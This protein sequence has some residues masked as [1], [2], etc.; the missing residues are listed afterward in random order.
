MRALVQTYLAELRAIF[1]D[2]GVLLIM[3][4]AIFL[5]SFVYPVPYSDEILREVDVVVVDLDHTALSRQ[6]VRM[7]DASDLI[8]ISRRANNEEEARRMVTLGRASGVLAIP[9]DF[10]RRILRS[11]AAQVG[12]YADASYFLVYRQVLT[13]LVGASRT[14]S[15]GIEVRRLQAQGWFK[16]KALAARDPLQFIGFALFNPYLG[17]ATYIVP[18]VLVLLLQQTMLIGVGMLAGTRRESRL[19]GP[20]PADRR[21]GA[22]TILWG[23]AGAYLTVYFIHV[24]FI[25]GVVYRVWG[26]P[27]RNGQG[28]VALFLFPYLLSVA[29]LSQALAG[30]FKSREAAIPFLAWTSVVAVMVSGFSWPPEAMPIW[31]KALAGLLP[32][33]WG[34][35]G[36]LRVS[37]MG[38]DLSQVGVDWAW[39][40]GL[41]AGYAVLGWL[42]VRRELRRAAE[43]LTHS[44]L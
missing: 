9:A 8:R 11:E 15:A 4:G 41:S 38:A 20:A 6:L 27:L 33:T 44:D 13:A 37:Q 22:G 5:Y 36:L 12:V 16:E 19:T 28:I 25:Y 1:S 32:S 23:R 40:W 3:V 29:M 42:S 17:Y 21:G 30:L 7:A 39:L 10:E 14:L 24:V 31:M 2:K 34:I 18:A 43:P 35:N 26:L